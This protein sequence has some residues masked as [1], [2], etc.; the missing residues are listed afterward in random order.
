M[1]QGYV[2]DITC[3]LSLATCRSVDGG[4]VR[5][6]TS[7]YDSIVFFIVAGDHTRAIQVSTPSIGGLMKYA[8]K[9]ATCLGCKAPLK[10]GESAV[11]ANCKFREPELFQKQRNSVNDLEERFSR[12][13]TQ[14]QRCQGS[15][16][17]EVLCTS[18]DCPIFYMRKKVQKEIHDSTMVLNR[19]D[20]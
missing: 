11:C 15:L 9:T 5:L 1:F 16:H 20:W 6:L 13:W 17:Q 19:F 18:R 10:Q 2:R 4:I 14:C 3:R 12:L 8:V 7:L